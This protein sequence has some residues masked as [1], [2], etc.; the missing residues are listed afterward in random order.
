[1]HVRV[2]EGNKF[3]PFVPTANVKPKAHLRLYSKPAVIE[4]Y[5]DAAIYCLM[6]TIMGIP[7]VPKLDDI[8]MNRPQVRWYTS[9]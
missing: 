3:L 2:Y 5:P 6:G 4:V 1:M 8:V 9:F 7:F